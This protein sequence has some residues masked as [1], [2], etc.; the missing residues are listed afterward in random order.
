MCA[1]SHL[2]P[3]VLC[4]HSRLWHAP[5]QAE[6]GFP[7][8]SSDEREIRAWRL[9]REHAQMRRLSE[10]Q[11][12]GGAADGKR[13]IKTS[14]CERTEAEVVAQQLARAEGHEAQQCMERSAASTRT[15]EAPFATSPAVDALAAAADAVN[16]TDTEAVI[17]TDTFQQLQPLAHAQ[18]RPSKKWSSNL[19]SSWMAA[20]EVSV[21]STAAA[22]APAAERTA[23]AV[24]ASPSKRKA[25][26][27]LS[28]AGGG[29]KVPPQAK[30]QAHA[31]PPGWRCEPRQAPGGQKYNVYHGPP[32]GRQRAQSVAQ[33]WACYRAVVS[34]QEE[35]DAANEPSAVRELDEERSSEVGGGAVE[36]EDQDDED[37]D[38]PVE[39]CIP[40]GYEACPWAPGQ[41][42][43]WFMLWQ[44]PAV[45]GDS[46]WS[47]G[48]V[49]K[50][51]PRN[52]DYTHDAWLQGMPRGQK[53]GPLGVNL[54]Q[55]HHDDDLSWVLLRKKT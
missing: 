38:Q 2:Q 5:S 47:F 11:R 3:T 27:V 18:P 36:S 29:R 31:L 16:S 19:R 21:A 28:Q 8:W 12:K 22:P 10:A 17:L 4:V 46:Q 14:L 48:Q 23:P 52:K 7:F 54:S 20:P 33:A 53:R 24:P 30:R 43:H 1:R 40:E 26:A 35:T 37:E 15:L 55:R 49:K 50:A 41:A 34:A 42:V 45:R 13:Q 32:G 25:A 6:F 51:L 39:A 9:S 44:P